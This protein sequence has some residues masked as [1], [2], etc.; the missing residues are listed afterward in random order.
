MAIEI[1]PSA[2]IEATIESYDSAV[3]DA[4]HGLDADPTR[5]ID[6]GLFW[7]VAEG[8]EIGLGPADVAGA[9]VDAMRAAKAA[10]VP[11]KSLSI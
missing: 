2:E 8:H 6:P 9:I 4:L 7:I 3:S 11:Q 10:A 5:P 1:V